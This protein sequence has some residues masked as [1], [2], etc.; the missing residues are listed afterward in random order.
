MARQNSVDE[1]LLPPPTDLSQLTR[2]ELHKYM[3]GV[4]KDDL[5]KNIQTKL[6]AHVSAKPVA[7]SLVRGSIISADSKVA[8]T[9]FKINYMRIS[10]WVGYDSASNSAIPIQD[11]FII[12]ADYS[13][14]EKL[15]NYLMTDKKVPNITMDFSKNG[16]QPPTRG[17]SMA[18]DIH[19]GP[20]LTIAI[21]NADVGTVFKHF[22]INIASYQDL[23]L[24]ADALAKTKCCYS[25]GKFCC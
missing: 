16:A 8:P 14:W 13:S 5:E 15:F 21:R 7:S 17:A 2:E 6:K 20:P 19:I 1:K 24:K 10:N 23:L 4:V 22:D 3:N 12:C 9:P 18:H 11:V 25:L